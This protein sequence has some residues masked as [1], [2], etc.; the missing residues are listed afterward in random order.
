MQ[1]KEPFKLYILLS[2]IIIVAQSAE[3]LWPPEDHSSKWNREVSIFEDGAA[4]HQMGF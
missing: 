2:H 3:E 1:M 4:H